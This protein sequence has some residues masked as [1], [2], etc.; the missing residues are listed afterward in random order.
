MVRKLPLVAPLKRRNHLSPAVKNKDRRIWLLLFGRAHK[1]VHPIKGA[2][3]KE[4]MVLTGKVNSWPSSRIL[5]LF[6]HPRAR[7]TYLTGSINDHRH[8]SPFKNSRLA[9][10][11][12][13]WERLEPLFKLN[14]PKHRYRVLFGKT[15]RQILPNVHANRRLS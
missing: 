4:Y 5:N 7:S 12:R 2:T 9:P 8:S 15:P 3:R 13:N 11:H 10:S 14:K 6:T 1:L